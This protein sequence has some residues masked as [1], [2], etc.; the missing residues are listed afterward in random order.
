MHRHFC[1]EEKCSPGFYRA[2]ALACR[3]LELLLS[4]RERNPL[5]AKMHTRLG[6]A[7]VKKTLMHG[8][9]ESRP[10]KTRPPRRR[11][12]SN[13]ALKNRSICNLRPTSMSNGKHF[14]NAMGYVTHITNA[15]P[16]R[17]GVLTTLQGQPDPAGGRTCSSSALYAETSRACD[18]SSGAGRRNRDASTTTGG[19]PASP[20]LTWAD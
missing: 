16:A 7:V 9:G 1:E 4:L 14:Q 6:T 3:P 18:A 12:R 8:H 20:S 15:R 13:L 17:S 2:A 19:E 5:S 11:S 10:L